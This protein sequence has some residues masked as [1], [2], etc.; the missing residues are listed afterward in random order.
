MTHFSTDGRTAT[1][2]TLFKDK[3]KKKAKDQSTDTP[4][5]VQMGEHGRYQV[6]SGRLSGEYVARAFPRPPTNARGMIAEAKGA[7]EE[8]AIAALHG[9]IDAR[10]RKRTEER[11][12][13]ALTGATVPSAAEY[14]EAISQVALSRPQRAMLKALSVADGGGLSEM[15]MAYA[16]GYKSGASANRAFSAAG[17]LIES[18]LSIET[19]SGP[20]PGDADGTAY[21]GCRGPQRN[22]T[23]PG[24][25]ILHPELREAVLSAL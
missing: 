10:E 19:A 17:L 20:L 8:A 21:L 13:D 15:Q 3:P 7:T 22:D 25:W 2:R 14:V 11:R 9:L 5:A 24:N 1:G 16:A 6:K 23:D 4:K 18:Y 12:T